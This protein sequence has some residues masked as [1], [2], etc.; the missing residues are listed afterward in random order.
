M[1]GLTHLSAGSGLDVLRARI[2]EYRRSQRLERLRVADAARR[3][4]AC[5]EARIALLEHRDLMRH[6]RRMYAIMTRVISQHEAQ[7]RRES[8]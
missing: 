3:Q 2:S 6:K 8:A 5:L 1:P 7:R 4:Q